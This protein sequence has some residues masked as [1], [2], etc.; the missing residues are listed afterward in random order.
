[1]IQLIADSQLRVKELKR[2]A[3]HNTEVILLEDQTKSCYTVCL[4]KNG[5]EL[6]RVSCDD[7]DVGNLI[8]KLIDTIPVDPKFLQ[9]N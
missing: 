3:C 7:N 8:C 2:W 5:K 4:E 9:L 6:T 1:M